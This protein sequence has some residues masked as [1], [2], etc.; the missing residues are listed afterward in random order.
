[1]DTIKRYHRSTVHMQGCWSYDR[2]TTQHFLI[3]NEIDLYHELPKSN[4]PDNPSKA[5]ARHRIKFAPEI[6][7]SIKKNFIRL[8]PKEAFSELDG[9]AYTLFKLFYAP[10]DKESVVHSLK[11]MASY[12]GWEGKID[13]F[14]TWVVSSLEILE[15][16]G[17][18]LWWKKKEDCFEACSNALRFKEHIDKLRQLNPL[19]A[20]RK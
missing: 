14:Q 4:V 16:R 8:F 10:T 2:F 5:E 17:F 12:L 15:K 6:V 18:V 13:N 20:E 19:K 11:Y 3:I 7:E 9:E 1:M